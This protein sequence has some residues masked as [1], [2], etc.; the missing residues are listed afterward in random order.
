M[1]IIYLFLAVLF[2]SSFTSVSLEDWGKTGHRTVG[3]IAEQHLTR[4]AKRNIDNL[5]NGESLA[6]AAYYADEIKSDDLYR[7]YYYWHFVNFPFD[8]TY[9]EHPKSEK[10]DLFAAINTCVKIL[11]DEANIGNTDI[12]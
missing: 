3:E 7:E 4:K 10:G 12:V 6:E 8:S 9:E 11:K 1:K 5:L 2:L